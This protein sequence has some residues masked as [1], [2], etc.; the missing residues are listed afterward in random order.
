MNHLTTCHQLQFAG[1]HRWSSAI[2]DIILEWQLMFGMFGSVTQKSFYIAG[3]HLIENGCCTVARRQQCAGCQAVSIAECR[4]EGAEPSSSA[5]ASY[6][7]DVYDSY[8]F[9]KKFNCL[10]ITWHIILPSSSMAACRAL[11]SKTCDHPLRDNIIERQIS[12]PKCLKSVPCNKFFH[13]A[14][15]ENLTNS[16]TWCSLR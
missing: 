13:N 3:R 5:Y 1:L 14:I 11:S 15:P 9:K 4:V 2:R 10:L 6:L 16:A 7:S 8:L 12:Q